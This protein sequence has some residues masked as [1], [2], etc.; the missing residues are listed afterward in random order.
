M[1]ISVI[2]P[3]FN[4]RPELLS[5]AVGSVLEQE[6]DAACEVVLVDDG[7]TAVETLDALRRLEQQ[8][9][10]VKVIRPGRNGGPARARN[11]GLEAASGDWI[12]FIDADDLWPAG[13][14]SHALAV[15]RECPDTQ[16]IGGN[17]ADLGPDARLTP[18][19]HVTA[20][21]KPVSTGV[22]SKRLASTDLTRALISGWLH[23]GTSFVRKDLIQRAGG[24]DERVR[25]GEDWLLFARMSI[26]AP[27]DFHPQ[28]AYLLRRQETSMMRSFG[29]M[30][31]RYAAC[32]RLAR[33]DPMFENFRRE[34]RWYDYGL[35]KDMAMN[36]LINRRPFHAFLFSLKALMIS[37]DEIKEFLLFLKIALCVDRSRQQQSLKRYS[38]AEQVDLGAF[39]HAQKA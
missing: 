2:C 31:S 7:S 37:P 39:Q 11:L 24:F 33:H 30:S 35:H 10:Q 16:W 27:M 5:K 14:L 19:T 9:P 22:F 12:G 23:L 1:K 29:R 3:V 26:H 18:N 34:L 25:Y 28:I 13:K 6:G 21:C 4:A 20:G 17:F 38:S 32:A 15:H 36:N 8:H